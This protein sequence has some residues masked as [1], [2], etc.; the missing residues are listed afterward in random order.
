MREH[1][2]F[3]FSYLRWWFFPTRC[4]FPFP[5]AQLRLRLLHARTLFSH[6]WD[7]FPFGCRFPLRSPLVHL[8]RHRER[9]KGFANCDICGVLW[10][11]GFV[12]VGTGK[13]AVSESSSIVAHGGRRWSWRRG[14]GGGEDEDEGAEE[15]KAARRRSAE[16]VGLSTGPE[17]PNKNRGKGRVFRLK[18][19]DEKRVRWSARSSPNIFLTIMS[20]PCSLALHLTQTN[21]A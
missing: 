9:T 3:S 12:V 6:L 4:R 1:G 5:L 8:G 2:Q 17:V 16:D 14:G 13:S 7:G 11:W 20:H 10:Q 21:T 18:N 15:K 19:E